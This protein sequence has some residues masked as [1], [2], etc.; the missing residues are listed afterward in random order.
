MTVNEQIIV[1]ALWWLIGAIGFI[2][3]WTKKNKLKFKSEH[4]FPMLILGIM[5]PLTW[6]LLSL[7]KPI[8]R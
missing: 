4:I 5:G 7:L 2:Y 8:D 6:P 1:I 3:S